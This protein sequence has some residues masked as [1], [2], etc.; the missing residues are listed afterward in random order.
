MATA[1]ANIDKFLAGGFEK[2]QHTR[3]TAGRPYGTLPTAGQGAGMTQVDG[4]N[5]AN[6][7][8]PPSQTLQFPG[9]NTVRGAIMFAPDAA[10]TLDLVLADFAGAFVDTVQGT[11]VVDAQS[12]YNFYLLNPSNPSFPDLFLLLSQ[13]ATSKVAGEEGRGFNSLA[14][15]LCSVNY[16]GPGGWATGPNAS[17][18]TFNVTVNPVSVLPWGTPLTK[19]THGAT[20]VSGFI[21][22]SEEIPTFDTF[23]QNFATAT[24]EPS[25]ALNANEQVIGFDGAELGTPATLAVGFSTPDFTFTAQADGNV[26][27]FLYEIA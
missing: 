11:T 8:F 25:Q 7:T 22:F 14:L 19:A 12:I 1:L 6:F 3:S 27:T 2:L 10:P 4:A 16:V 21:F 24:Y 5:A 23:H 20:E 9:D 18:N 15:P 17:L 26:T 13:K